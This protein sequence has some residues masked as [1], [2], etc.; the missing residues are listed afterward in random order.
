MHIHSRRAPWGVM[1]LASIGIAALLIGFGFVMLMLGGLRAL[2]TET[3]TTFTGNWSWAPYVITLAGGG[4]VI[5]LAAWRIG[6]KSAKRG[7]S[8]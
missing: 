1:S 2:Q 3:G 8:T 4:V 7:S 5:G 6:A